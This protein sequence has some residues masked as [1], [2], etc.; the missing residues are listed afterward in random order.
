[1]PAIGVARGQLNSTC[2]CFYLVVMRRRHTAACSH[3][4]IWNR[5]PLTRPAGVD[6]RV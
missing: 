6:Y 3:R 1:V 2:A 5:Y 4:P